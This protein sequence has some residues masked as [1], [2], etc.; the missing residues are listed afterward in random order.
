LIAKEWVHEISNTLDLW[1]YVLSQDTA[2]GYTQT[3]PWDLWDYVLYWM[4]VLSWTHISFYIVPAIPVW[5]T[6]DWVQSVV[7]WTWI[8]VD[9]TDPL[10]PII[11]ATWGSW[12]VTS[13]AIS[14][15]DG[16]EVD[17]GSPITTTGT[18]ALWVNKTTMLSH[19]NV[20]DWADV[21]D[22]TNVGAAW[23]FM[24]A[25]DDTDD[26]TVGATN[27]FATA[28]EKTKLWYI[29]V[30][31]A[32]DLDTMESDIAGKQPLDSDLTTIAWLTAT[33]D[34]FIQSKA[35]AWASRT[36][37]QVKTDLWLTWT[38]SWD[39]TS[40]V[41][42]TW[43]KA[44]FDTAVTDWNFLYV[45]DITQYTDEL[46]QDAVWAMI[47]GSLTYV[48]WTPLLQRAALTWAITASAWSNT[49]VLGSFTTAQL[50]TA[51]SD[52]DVATWWGT[53][54]WTN[55]WDQ[56]IFST[57]SVSWQSNVVADS[58]SDTL[59]L[60][61]WTNVTITTDAWT[62]SITINASGWGWTPWGSDWQI[63]YNN[64][65]SFWW[66]PEITWDDTTKQFALVT[67]LD[68]S[69]INLFCQNTAE[70]QY[71][72]VSMTE[73]SFYFATQT[74][75]NIIAC[76]MDDTGLYFS[77]TAWVWFNSW[78]WTYT[79]CNDSWWSSYNTRYASPSPAYPQTKTNITIVSAW[80]SNT[81]QRLDIE[82]I[83][84]NTTLPSTSNFLLFF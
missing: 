71:S 15:T 33:S 53:A 32:V 54:S 55:T 13:V 35:W 19:L 26:I 17:S 10:N 65:G 62:D 2:W 49:T 81:S 46:A 76:S 78:D 45:W 1:E 77:S 74:A 42:I 70:V 60:V 11:N 72:A 61:A 8:T 63:Q 3:L 73:S 40:I 58:T 82:S 44:Q 36:I 67:A 75:T 43:T 24:K 69:M 48:D 39:Q 51:L 79:L 29:T 7:A 47:D 66:A 30:T 16:L 14:W 5:D 22:A 6:W 37:A 84:T 59:T 4:E 20:E 38:N 80:W 57:I 56:N 28:T 83:T 27:K 18:I 25:V 68:W 23:A 64:W 50:N 31:Q 34:N 21:T 12:T 52:W 41:W 9:N